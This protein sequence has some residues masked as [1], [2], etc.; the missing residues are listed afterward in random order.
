MRAGEAGA[1]WPQGTAIAV[2]AA[3]V[4]HPAARAAERFLQQYGAPSGDP[5]PAGEGAVTA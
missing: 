3:V 2:V 1:H 5:T 4:A